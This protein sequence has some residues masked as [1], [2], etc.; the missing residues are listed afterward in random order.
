M[1]KKVAIIGAGCSGLA[2]IKCCLAEGLEPTCFEQSSDIGGLWRFEE[3]VDEGRASLYRSVVTN[4]SKEMM[5]YS[6]FPMP[7]DFPVYLHHAKV[8]EY[9]YLYAEHFKLLKYIQ[10]HTKVCSVKKHSDFSTTG[11]WDIIAEKDGKKNLSIFD[12]VMICNGHFSDPYLPL[13]SFPGIKHFKDHYIHSR[14]YKSPDNYRGKT[15]L[16]VGTGNSGVDI[17]VEIGF[18][19]KQVFLSTKDGT[20][21]ISRIA[22]GGCPLDMSLSRRCTMLMMKFLPSALVGKVMEKLLGSWFDHQ[23]YGLKPKNRMKPPIINDYLPSLILQGTVKVRPNV[24]EFTETSAIF[25]DGTEAR[26]LDEIIF[27]TGYNSS[28]PFLDDAIITLNN[29]KVSMYKSVFPIHMEKPT[30]TFL[31]LIQPLGAILPL[32][33]LQARWATRVFKGATELP[34]QKKMEEYTKQREEYTKKWFGTGRTQG[35]QIHYIDYINEVSAELGNHPNIIWLFLTDPKLAL[36]VFFGPCTPY[37]Y[38]LTGPGK[39]HGA[40]K[41][42]LTQWDRTLKPL[43]TRIP[44]ANPNSK[45]SLL[46]LLGFSALMAAVCFG[47]QCICF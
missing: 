36:Q 17:A 22:H 43:R 8:F 33:E 11:Q 32:V 13:A 14:F 12:A 38:R 46:K 2:A 47:Y 19:A 15:V 31:G 7:R 23:N 42:I 6:D 30:M 16:I 25:E 3:T 34:S 28:L 5:C 39:W 10:F 20:W 1:I 18:I 27:A 44:P 45:S 37:Q 29:N 4:T 24:K 35:L 21:V 9:L 26:N 41:T 40:R